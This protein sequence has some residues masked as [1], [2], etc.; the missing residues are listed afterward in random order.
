MHFAVIV[1]VLVC[2]LSKS[3]SFEVA[4]SLQLLFQLSPSPLS[5][6]TR[7]PVIHLFRQCPIGH[8]SSKPGSIRPAPITHN[9]LF[10]KLILLFADAHV[11]PPFPR[12]IFTGEKGLPLC[13]KGGK[14]FR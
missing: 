5:N 14:D 4:A 8:Y 2:E 1:Q 12:P 7:D 11:V 13:W 10:T 6:R 9:V 3:H